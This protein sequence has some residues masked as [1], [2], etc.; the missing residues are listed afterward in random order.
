MSGPVARTV[1]C[2]AGQCGEIGDLF[3]PDL[4]PRERFELRRDGGREAVAIDREGAPGRH[5]R[6]A[7]RPDDQRA[8]ELHLALEEAGGMLRVVAAQRVRAHQL[9]EVAALV[10][11]RLAHWS[12]LVE[13]HGHPARGE[14]KGA[15][16]AGEASTDDMDRGERGGHGL[17]CSG[18]GRGDEA[19]E[20]SPERPPFRL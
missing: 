6:F 10:R 9:G 15:L 18:R 8:E 17:H 13:H 7:R 19:L 4:E 5:R 2:S 20:M 12:H 14:L 1:S 3:A 11:R 16:A